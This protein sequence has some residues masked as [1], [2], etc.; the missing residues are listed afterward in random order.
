MNFLNI[1]KNFNITLLLNYFIGFIYTKLFFKKARLIRRPFYLRNE[2]KFI[3]DSGLSLGPNALIEIFGHRSQLIIGKNFSAYFN[4]HIACCKH[5]SIGDNV[6]VA[7]NVYIS[8]HL[9]G[10]YK[11][12]NAS[13]ISDPNTEPVKRKISSDPITIGN[14]VW[15]GEGVK[16]LPGVNIGSGSILGAGSVVSKS[17][18]KNTICVGIPAKP[19]KKFDLKKNVWNKI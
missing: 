3:F 16:I 14:N 17:I 4:L 10:F 15:I 9:H 2:G 13:L 1:I 11:N 7:S 19:I 18:P 8:D 12:I 5:I 6:L